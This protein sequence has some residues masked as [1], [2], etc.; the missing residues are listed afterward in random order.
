MLIM[1]VDCI[2]TITISAGEEPLNY[3]V[4][5]HGDNIEEKYAIGPNNSVSNLVAQICN[6]LQIDARLPESDE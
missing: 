6:R 4:E 1:S 3:F 5:V 2:F